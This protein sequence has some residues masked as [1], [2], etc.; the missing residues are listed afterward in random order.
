MKK[1]LGVLLVAALVLVFALS[2]TAN[3]AGVARGGVTPANLPENKHPDKKVT[4]EFPTPEVTIDAVTGMALTKIALLVGDNYP[5]TSSQLN[6]CVYDT[7]DVHQ[8]LTT[9]YGFPSQNIQYL[10]NQQCTD[11]NIKAGIQ[12]LIANSDAN[13]TVVF[14]YSGHG[15]KSTKCSDGDGIRTDYSIVPYDMTRIWDA[16]LA[17]LFG[18]LASQRAWIAFD[19]CF[20]GGLTVAGTTGAGRVDTFA[21]AAKEYSYESSTTQHG[22]FTYLLVHKGMLQATA[23]GN[24]DGVV[25]VEEAFNYCKA[26]MGILTRSQHPN[27][28]DQYSGDL[29]LGI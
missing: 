25:T 26:N 20:S 10:K 7:D 16:Q 15:S 13:S 19:S 17:G 3:A 9:A 2:F 11:A 22:Y 8:A 5:G 18:P 28:N 12:W 21:C 24:G 29:N 4:V 6:Y 27:M 1:R 14:Y 23:D